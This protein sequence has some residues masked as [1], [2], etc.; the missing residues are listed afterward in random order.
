MNEH[1]KKLLKQLKFFLKPHSKRQLWKQWH[2]YL[3]M[4]G[5]GKFMNY[6]KAT[7]FMHE[8]LSEHEMNI[9]KNR[10]M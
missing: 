2:K 4:C 10:Q 1:D 7:V 6:A 3:Y 5:N 9:I 8:N